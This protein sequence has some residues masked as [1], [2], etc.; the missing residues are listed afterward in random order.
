MAFFFLL[1]FF[2]HRRDR[3][4]KEILHQATSH[5]FVLSEVCPSIH[6]TM[7]S[8]ASSWV[9]VT[10]S[11]HEDQYEVDAV[12][13]SLRRAIDDAASRSAM[14]PSLRGTTLSAASPS[15]EQLGFGDDG[16]DGQPQSPTLA[17]VTTSVDCAMSHLSSCFHNFLDAKRPAPSPLGHPSSTLGD[18][19]GPSSVVDGRF[20]A[21]TRSW[22]RRTPHPLAGLFLASDPCALLCHPSSPARSCVYRL[23]AQMDARNGLSLAPSSSSRSTW[24]STTGRRGIDNVASSAAA[25]PS[26][27]TSMVDPTSSAREAGVAVAICS[28]G[29]TS[30]LSPLTYKLAASAGIVTSPQAPT[31]SSQLGSHRSSSSSRLDPATEA[32]AKRRTISIAVDDVDVPTRVDGNGQASSSP[33]VHHT[34]VHLELCSPVEFDKLVDALFASPTFLSAMSRVSLVVQV[35]GF[36]S[37]ASLGHTGRTQRGLGSISPAQGG[38]MA[39]LGRGSSHPGGADDSNS[40]SGGL[41]PGLDIVDCVNYWHLNAIHYD[42]YLTATAATENNNASP[43]PVPV[44]GRPRGGPPPPPLLSEADATAGLSLDFVVPPDNIVAACCVT[45]PLLPGE[46]IQADGRDCVAAQ[47]TFMT[48]LTALKVSAAQRF[49]GGSDAPRENGQRGD[50]VDSLT[51]DEASRLTSSLHR[52]LHH[53]AQLSDRLDQLNQD[54]SAIIQATEEAN[55]RSPE[56]E[57]HQLL[58]QSWSMVHPTTDT[59]RLQGELAEA[60]QKLRW[61]AAKL[62]EERAFCGSASQRFKDVEAIR[63][64]TNVERMKVDG[65]RRDIMNVAVPA[66]EARR[67]ALQARLRDADDD[68]RF[69]A[70]DEQRGAARLRDQQDAD[71]QQ[72]KAEL[73]RLVEARASGMTIS[74]RTFVEIAEAHDRELNQLAKVHGEEAARLR[75]EVAKAATAAENEH[76]HLVELQTALGVSLSEGKSLEK[77]QKILDAQRDAMLKTNPELSGASRSTSEA[78]LNARLVQLEADVEVQEQLKTR[79]HTMLRELAIS[80]SRATSDGQ[81]AQAAYAEHGAQHAAEFAVLQRREHAA[82]QTLES[83][84]RDV[85]IMEATIAWEDVILIQER[86]NWQRVIEAAEERLHERGVS[87]LRQ[88]VANLRSQLH[89]A[90]ERMTTTETMKRIFESK[91][92]DVL[93]EHATKLQSAQR[94]YEQQLEKERA[95]HSSHALKELEGERLQVDALMHSTEE[96]AALLRRCLSRVP[97]DAMTTV[98]LGTLPSPGEV[99]VR[100]QRLTQRASQRTSECHFEVSSLESKLRVMEREV[101]QRSEVLH[102]V[103]ENVTALTARLHD[104]EDKAQA[105]ERAAAEAEH[106]DASMLKVLQEESLFTQDVTARHRAE[107]EHKVQESY[108]S[109]DELQ[110]TAQLSQREVDR[111]R[112]RL[113]ELRLRNTASTEATLRIELEH[114]L[115]RSR[116]LR[117]QLEDG[118]VGS[119]KAALLSTSFH[120]S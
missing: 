51:P 66:L 27:P 76:V 14:T 90:S 9:V 88:E 2:F 41:A 52:L 62:Q 84:R 78:E 40:T 43:L 16:A 13:P 120:R 45:G 37:L 18:G 75:D 85:L 109:L 33:S 35:V 34:T 31:S 63:N 68:L 60:E 95:A 36:S 114:E 20:L 42:G 19:R 100:L 116:S 94:Q 8:T 54:T 5:S 22:L 57:Q 82:C 67:G 113:S 96:S 101:E 7:P 72:H 30:T 108:E 50:G 98:R 92:A 115:D 99:L 112:Q 29:R 49:S 4:R 97:V 58:P 17:V 106:R 118:I 89:M 61:L 80:L 12:N 1:P 74:D 77:D 117:S 56:N 83:R 26:S 102:R 55:A 39:F 38:R 11:S 110:K 87:D 15:L 107:G 86:L 119:G 23:F 104:I 6:F 24:M 25:E 111:L 48:H 105:A 44:A 71:V 91:L 32:A 21:D 93:S 59:G 47:T 103:R 69:K 79:Y 10:A 81:Q 3:C 64:R 28:L 73:S 46:N 53:K 70:V 65:E